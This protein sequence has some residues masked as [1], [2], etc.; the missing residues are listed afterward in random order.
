[1]SAILCSISPVNTTPEEI[2]F[3]QRRMQARDTVRTHRAYC[4]ISV[5]GVQQLLHALF[6]QADNQQWIHFAAKPLLSDIIAVLKLPVQVL[7]FAL[8]SPQPGQNQRHL[9]GPGT[10]SALD[11]HLLVTD[12]I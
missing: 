7:Q 10:F 8:S 6:C 3:L 5:I 9:I 12:P 4:L 11:P 1:M 2:L